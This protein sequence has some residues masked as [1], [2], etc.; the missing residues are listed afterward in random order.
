MSDNIVDFKLILNDK[1]FEV[2]AKNAGKLLKQLSVDAGLASKK[3]SNL[4]VSDAKHQ[5]L[6]RSSG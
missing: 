2:S 1:E 4:D 5:N 3:I 6:H